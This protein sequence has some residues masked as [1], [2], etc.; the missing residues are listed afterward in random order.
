MGRATSI[1]AWFDVLRS[2]PVHR[3]AAAEK[4]P[5]PQKANMN[6]QELNARKSA[7]LAQ[8]ESVLNAAQEQKRKLTDVE[9]ASFSNA[10]NEIKDI[11]QTLIRF[12]AIAK[13]KAEIG[14]PSSKIVIPTAKSA[15][16]GKIELSEEYH[17]SFWA[18][19]RG[20]FRN[21]VDSLHEGSNSEGG[22]LVPVTVDGVIV[23]LAPQ[24][25]ALRQ[26]ALVIPTQ[27]DIKLPAQL[28]R[29]AATSKSETADEASPN[30]FGFTKPTFTQTTLSA[31]IA[32]GTVPVSLELAEDVPALQPF[33]QNDLSRIIAEYEDNKFVNGTGSGEPQ[34]ILA[35][36]A[37]QTSALTAALSLD[38]LG[39]LKAAY[40]PNA[41]FLMHRATGIA[42]RK[43]QLSANQFNQYWT[44]SNGVDYLHGYKVN[45]S[46]A[47]PVFAASPLV[48]GKIAFGDF[49]TCLT[50]GDRFNGGVRIT[51]DNI[52]RFQ[53]GLIL[54][55]GFRR[56]DSRIRV[57]E[58]VKIWTVNG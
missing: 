36:D 2:G 21:T 50:I 23:P 3:L 7:L 46:S 31:F 11:D 1:D 32:G 13:G 55:N 51:V 34:G 16:H 33:L 12:D 49:K 43:A 22:Y 38:F 28:T 56:T 6:R 30:S 45:Y 37:G 57:S 41:Q 4:N 44:S 18:G 9:E 5:R 15:K 47:M 39:T 10:T 54:V 35:A 20:G 40:Y 42:F 24:E 19:V 26:L 58:A 53:D 52:T 17:E 29:S 27:H 25:T 8:Q 48:N 14:A